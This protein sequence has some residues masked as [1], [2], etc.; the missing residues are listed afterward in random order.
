MRRAADAR[1]WRMSTRVPLTSSDVPGT[2]H[3]IRAVTLQ[4]ATARG[5]GPIA[6]KERNDDSTN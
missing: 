2:P 3:A 5:A 1:V 6:T 4:L